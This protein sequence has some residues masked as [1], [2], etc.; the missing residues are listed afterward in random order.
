MIS[1]NVVISN[2]TRNKEGLRPLP[3]EL[4]QLTHHEDLLGENWM[5]HVGI[6][7]EDQYPSD[8]YQTSTISISQ[9][10]GCEVALLSLEGSAATLL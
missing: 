1:G 3:C 2:S 10:S 9:I 4:L 5:T 6:R 8:D 7:S